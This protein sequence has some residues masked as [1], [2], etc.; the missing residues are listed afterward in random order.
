MSVK[1]GRASSVN[2]KR[3]SWGPI[4]MD[5]DGKSK[6]ESDY[7]PLKD[8]DDSMASLRSPPFS[9]SRCLR[10]VFRGVV[11]TFTIHKWVSRYRWRDQLPGD[12]LAGATVGV[13]AVPQAMSYALVAGMPG[14]IYGLYNALMGLL[15]YFLFGTSP[16]LISGPTAV[17]SILV[18]SSVPE[19]FGDHPGADDW[20]TIAVTLSFVA[21]TFQLILG[22]FKLG[23]LVEL[24]SEPVIIGFTSGSA[25]L[26]AATQFSNFFGVPKC[27][28]TPCHFHESIINVF[29]H[30]RQF[31]GPTILFGIISLAFLLV[32]KFPLKR[33]VQGTRFSM[34]PALAPML[35]LVFSIVIISYGDPNDKWGI[36]TV[37]NICDSAIGVSCLPSPKFPL[38]S[39]FLRDIIKLIPPGISIALIGYMES[40]T[41]AK[42][43][44]RKQREAHVSSIL[45]SNPSSLPSVTSTLPND[46]SSSRDEGGTLQGND[47]IDPSQELIALGMCNLVCSFFQGYPVTGSFSRT[48]VNAATGA[49]SP[50]SSMFAGIIVMMALLLATSL[51]EHTPKVT[52]AV[53]V[54]SAITNLI[55]PKEIVLLWKVSHRDFWACVVVFLCTLFFG[56]ETALVLGIV[57]NWA[58]TL[59]HNNKATAALLG[60]QKIDGG[61][62]DYV[63]LSNAKEEQRRA[64]ENL[65]VMRLFSDLN[66]SSAPKFSRQVWALRDSLNPKAIVVDCTS[67]ND[68]DITGVHYLNIIA[69]ELRI[70]GTF[71]CLAAF[72]NP[73]YTALKRARDHLHDLCEGPNRWV[74]H[75][76]FPPQSSLTSSK[77]LDSKRYFKSAIME[78][79][80]G[81]PKYRP[82][83][84]GH[85]AMHIFHSR[86]CTNLFCHLSNSIIL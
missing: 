30:T 80:Q 77:Y 31:H 45:N 26:I 14:T 8:G 39:W 40:M 68:V 60:V 53:I 83:L 19:V 10:V 16:H 51:L 84:D 4:P 59:S 17:V 25:F 82:P 32:A 28:Y 6:K 55:E 33:W 56:V 38:K 43:C 67:V 12:V 48:A 75:S 42:T 49:S 22:F 74:F 11:G 47:K 61:V 54:L 58:I 57:C 65:A 1:S 76:R 2:G 15:P 86:E 34:L 52:L 27:K 3:D 46:I 21:G 35:L 50:L 79:K 24:V 29:S 81:E 66:F 73:S 23:F 72:P 63:D 69:S 85:G 7:Q 36:K 37:G 70:S 41:V 5:M 71:F 13:M 18:K 44:A 62:S 78:E 20:V 9:V 64:C